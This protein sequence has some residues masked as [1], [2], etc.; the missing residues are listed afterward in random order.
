MTTQEQLRTLQ[1]IGFNRISMG[2]QDFDPKVQQ[3]INRVQ[4]FEQ[5]RTIVEGARDLGFVSVNLDLVYGLPYPGP[6]TTF[7]GT[8]S[9]DFHRT[10]AGSHRLL[11]L[12]PRPL[13]Q[14]A[15]ARDP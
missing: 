13:A 9:S 3:T 4:S 10:L 11:Q 1:R 5:T 6:K 15:S 14:E 12:R 2:V 8:L 7:A